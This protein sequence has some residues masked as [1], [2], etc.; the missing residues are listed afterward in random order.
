MQDMIDALGSLRDGE[1]TRAA[2]GETVT[3]DLARAHRARTRSRLRRALGTGVVAVVAATVG[4]VG[5]TTGGG[6]H[7][8][9]A[10]GPS[11]GQHQQSLSVELDA[12]SGVQPSGFT[13]AT[14][15]AGWT[16]RTSDAS[17]FVVEP[18]RAQTQQTS[19][20]VVSFVN[21]IAVTLQG[22]SSGPAFDVSS[23][24]VDGHPGKLGLTEDRTAKWLDYTDGSG[25]QV[26]VQVPVS[27]RLADGRSVRLTDQQIVTF[28][29]GIAVTGSAVAA[30]G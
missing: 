25:H 12:Y 6:S 29:D 9:V 7:A 18:P 21:A 14:V 15:P 4:V 10:A 17:A 19:P 16:V 27:F 23:V 5:T 26:Q 3:A 13:V 22:D 8:E 11:A 2:D 24:T 30:V 28:A 1:A 20:G